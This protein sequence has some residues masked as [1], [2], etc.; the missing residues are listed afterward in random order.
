MERDLVSFVRKGVSV[1][2]Y[3]NIKC[4]AID[5]SVLGMDFRF[6][7]YFTFAPPCSCYSQKIVTKGHI[8]MSIF[9]IRKNFLQSYNML[10]YFVEV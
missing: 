9:Q 3:N 7:C 5:L 8:E 1:A 6:D 4:T 2:I 10:A